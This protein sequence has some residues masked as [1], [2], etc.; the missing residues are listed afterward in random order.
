MTEQEWLACTDPWPMR[1]FL[2]G[3][4]SER[5]RRLFAVAC[6][7]AVWPCLADQDKGRAV[8]VAERF[9]DGTASAAALKA[10]QARPL[11]VVRGRVATVTGPGTFGP[12]PA[13]F[14]L[15]PLR[16]WE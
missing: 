11:M 16:A 6:A 12:A 1:D 9:A 10:A 8:E 14:S 2:L 15:A 5:Q 7:R 13:G 3:K 4:A